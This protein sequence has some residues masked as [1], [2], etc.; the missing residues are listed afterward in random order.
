[1]NCSIIEFAKAVLIEVVKAKTTPKNTFFSGTSSFSDFFHATKNTITRRI[2][3]G[4]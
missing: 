4:F 3:H 1:L 2:L